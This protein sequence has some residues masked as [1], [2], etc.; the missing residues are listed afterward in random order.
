M[1]NSL[2]L[3]SPSG[4]KEWEIGFNELKIEEKI[5]KG[6]FGVVYKVSLKRK[7]LNGKGKWRNTPVAIKMCQ[8]IVPEQIDEF[9]R[10]AQLTV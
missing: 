1:E 2:E 4:K 9:I 6:S 8:S 7:R 3:A 5:G 10:E